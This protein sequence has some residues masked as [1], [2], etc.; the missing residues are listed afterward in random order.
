LLAE[1]TVAANWFRRRC[2]DDGCTPVS[3]SV[4]MVGATCPA[5]RV[6]LRDA[7][8][9][10]ETRGRRWAVRGGVR[11]ACVVEQAAPTTNDDDADDDVTDTLCACH[12]TDNMLP[13][14]RLR[15]SPG[16]HHQH[17]R[18]FVVVTQCSV[19]GQ[20]PVRPSF[21]STACRALMEHQALVSSADNYYYGPSSADNIATAAEG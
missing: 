11:P 19:P 17:H 14:Y 2:M 8:P 21:S 15:R 7:R 18:N 13:V 3:R 16:L 6:S 1:N 9:S 5:N 20:R 4:C 10:W 12:Y